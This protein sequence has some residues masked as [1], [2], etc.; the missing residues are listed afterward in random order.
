MLK[1]YFAISFILLLGAWIFRNFFLFYK[2][3]KLSNTLNCDNVLSQVSVGDNYFLCSSP[4]YMHGTLWLSSIWVLS[5]AIL[6]RSIR[7]RNKKK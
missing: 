5:V 1:K 7:A 3:T 6:F 2:F 4:G